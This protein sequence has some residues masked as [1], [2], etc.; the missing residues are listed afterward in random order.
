MAEEPIRKEDIIDIE[1]IIAGLQQII[2]LLK[3]DLVAALN[4]VKKANPTTTEGQ[5]TIKNV[6]DDI[7]AVTPQIK[8][9]SDL[10]KELIRR[11]EEL[12]RA[13]DKT[14]KEFS[15]EQ[16]ALLSAQR[17]M[18]GASKKAESYADGSLTDLEKQ[19]AKLRKEWK[20]FGSASGAS[21]KDIEKLDAQVKKLN[22]SIGNHQKNVGNYKSAIS[23]VGGSIMEAGKQ[24]FAFGGITGAATAIFRKF[25]DT[26]K[27]TELGANFFGKLKQ[28]SKSFFQSFVSGQAL[29]PF[30]VIKIALKDAGKAIAVADEFN[31]IRKDDRRELVEFTKLETE[32]SQLRYKAAD[33]TLTESEQLDALNLAIT[34]ENELR[35]LKIA[36]VNEE[37]LATQKMLKTRKA[38]TLLLD[39]EARL[40]AELNSLEGDKNLRLMTRASALREKTYKDSLKEASHL[41]EEKKITKE[42]EIKSLDELV[43][44]NKESLDEQLADDKK[45]KEVF[46]EETRKGRQQYIEDQNERMDNAKKLAEEE[47]QLAKEVRDAKIDASLQYMEIAS[48]SINVIADLIESSKQRELSAAGS[49]AQAR[50]KIEREYAKKQKLMSIS[51]AIINGAIGITTSMK[52]VPPL[53]FINAAVVAATTAAQIAIISAQKFAEGGEIKGKSHSQGGKMIEA[54][55]GEYVVRKQSTAKYKGLIEAINDDNPMRIAEEIRNRNFHTVWGGVSAQLS[56]VSKQDPYTRMMYE[57]MKNDIKT[58]IDSNGDT[59]L[60]YPDGSK[61]VIRKY[62]A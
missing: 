13:T 50:E 58:Y 4:A 21:T 34:K 18:D 5:Q 37:L 47:K 30:K 54:E 52:L 42:D 57:L 22:A 20:N 40:N 60:S 35:T 16:R 1:G 55:G 10:E 33:A 12:S 44:A 36:D 29:E 6:S 28:A 24:M 31:E 3:N 51:Q 41:G 15:A 59:V 2:D 48:Q 25:T 19:L 7:T 38:D 45:A 43:L 27:E 9:L 11:Q 53:N 46:D 14:N 23:G 26:L 61:R 56:Q 62:T 49:N 17:A 8:A 39:E 32:I